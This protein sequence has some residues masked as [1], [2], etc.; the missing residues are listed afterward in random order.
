MAKLGFIGV[1]LMGHGMAANLLAGGHEVVVVAHRNRTPVEDL[2]R[3]GAREA[4]AIADAA[5][6]P[7]SDLHLCRDLGPGQGDRR[8]ART[9][10]LP[11]AAD[12]RCRHLRS[13]GD[14]VELGQRLAGRDVHLVDAPMGGGAQQAEAG[15][16][17]S[18]VGASPGD[19]ATVEPWIRCYS[20]ICV[21]MGPVGAGHRAKLLNNLLALGQA[22]LVIEAYRMARDEGLDWHKL[23]QINMGGAAR[24]G[25]TSSASWCRRSP[26][27]TAAICS[28]SRIRS[29]ISLYCGFRSKKSHSH[30]LGQ[31]VRDF[32]EDAVAREGGALMVS[33]MLKP[34]G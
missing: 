6:G 25:S 5:A 2:V 34:K 14:E 10:A 20:T 28:P 22:A 18:L 30:R 23:Y 15:E 11:R 31:A 24:S 1:G 21:H 32:Y 19:Y 29:R 4:K 13:G 3:R 8:G 7:R 26:A 9:G 16:L 12:H 17:A 33:E 27:I